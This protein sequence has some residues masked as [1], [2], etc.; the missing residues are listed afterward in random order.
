MKPVA[1]IVIAGGPAESRGN[2]SRLLVSSGFPVFRCCASG[3]ELRRTLN[4][5][6]D[7]IVILLGGLPGCKPDELQWD[8]GDRVQIL[9]IGKPEALE[10]CE[11]PEVFRLALP[12]SGQALTGAVEMLSQLHQMRLPR[13]IDEEKQTVE[14]AKRLLMKRQS[15]T[16]P[17][18]HRALQ[19]YAMNHGMKMAECAAQLVQASQGTEE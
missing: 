4:E 19:Q 17:E 18:A 10:A 12:V 15:L 8:Y 2:L 7:G 1:R 5:C 16:E 13:R 9:L 14:R 6:D 11:A 3:S